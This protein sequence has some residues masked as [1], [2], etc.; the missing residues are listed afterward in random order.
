M[1]RINARVKPTITVDGEEFKDLNGD[2]ELQ[3]YEDW[4]LA[5]AER[6]A[7]LAARMEVDELVGLMVINSR[8]MGRYQKDPAKTSMDGL[9]DEEH[10]E[11]HR[12]GSP[13]L[14]GTTEIITDKHVRHFILRETPAPRHIVQWVNA[15]Q[16]VAEGTRLG[17]PVIV[18]SN[19][20]NEW[21][22]FRIMEQ[23]DDVL[24]TLWPGT[25]GLAAIGDLDLISDFAEK[26]RKEFRAINVRKGYMYMADVATDPRWFRFNGTFGED[27]VFVSEA[28]RRVVKGFQGEELGS[29]SIA[30]TTKHFPGGGA[31]ENG[32]DPHYAEGKYNCYPTPG[33]LENYHMPPFR[34]AVEAGTSS[35]MPYYAIPS[36]EK[37][38]M[39]QAPHPGEFEEVGFAFNKTIIDLLRDDLGHSGY[40]NSDS[41]VLA[42]M[43]WGVE[44]LTVPERVA[45][46]L[47]AGTD[48]LADTN[49]VASIRAAYDQGLVDRERLELS[50]RRLLTEMFTLGLFEDPYADPEV[51]DGIVADPSHRSAAAQAHR[52]SVVLLKNGGVLPLDC[53]ELG[54]RAVYLESFGKDL[55]VAQ[56][57]ELREEIAALDPEVRFTTDYREAD[58]AWVH[59]HPFTGDYFAATPE[60]LDLAIHEETNVRLAKVR[61]IREAVPTLIVSVNFWLPWLLHE[62]EPMADALLAGFDTRPSA[63]ADVVFGRFAPE[64]RL[65]VTLPAGPEAIAV[66]EDGQ[67]ASPNDVP[68]YD[69]ELHMDGRPYAYRDAAGN[70]YVLGFGLEY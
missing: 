30:L 33:S 28:I 35:V 51:A 42:D 69:K 15:L 52:R 56:L 48:I 37:S 24:M 45:K 12:F 7:D 6:A 17:V 60:P 47:A 59:L 49:D 2:G 10:Y 3:P 5:P 20:R 41:G 8:P 55:T 14:E 31:R 22:G 25:L 61:Q 43:A 13:Q 11:T 19:S 57:D 38:A 40:V 29:E 1:T 53:S 70:R 66:D 9:L 39:P 44:E 32:F 58:I 68:G 27:P 63:I 62:V 67:C 54:G 34:A 64:G 21:G 4:R 36:N 16:E 23:P 65:P 50:A 18:A 26:S 46:A